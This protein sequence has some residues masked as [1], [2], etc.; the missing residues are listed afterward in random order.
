MNVQTLIF[1]PRTLIAEGV[2][3]LLRRQPDIEVC[4]ICEHFSEVQSYLSQHPQID[5]L[6]WSVHQYHAK[7][8]DDVAQLAQGRYLP[9]ILFLLDQHIPFQWKSLGKLKHL[10]WG[11]LPIGATLGDF[12]MA[13]DQLL[14]GQVYLPSHILRTL[15]YE[16][17]AAHF[18]ARE[19][20]F[21][22][23]NV[24]DLT[25]KEMA[26]QMGHLSV[27]TLDTLRQ[28]LCAKIGCHSRVG[29]AVYAVRN[30]L[31]L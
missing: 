12:T 17:D 6:V 7:V 9:P 28:R 20:A 16:P 10:S 4:A 25:Y 15:A 31:D 29:L 3:A 30:R 27:R 24:L 19:L 26:I 11:L 1:E 18:T 5:L 21:L 22:K 2:A 23:W 14:E 8:L 13:V